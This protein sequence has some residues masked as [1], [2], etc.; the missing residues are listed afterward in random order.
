[1][2]DTMKIAVIGAGNIGTAMAAL[3]AQSGAEVTLVARG[4]RKAQ[5]EADG[6]RLDERGRMVT[7][8]P[9]VTEALAE[10]QDA[11][12]LCVKA[13]DLGAAV[14]ANRPGIGAGT[15]VIPM[16]NGLPF[17]FFTEGV[18]LADPDGALAGLDSACILGAVL[19]MTVRTEPD[20]TAVSSNTP[21]LTLAHALAGAGQGPA[22]ALVACLNA[23][24]VKTDLVADVRPKVLVKLLAN[25]ATNPLSALTGDMLA[26]IGRDSCLRALACAVAG[27]FRGWAAGLGYELPSDQWLVDLLLDAGDFPTSMLQDALAGRRLELDA[28]ARASLALS[29]ADGGDM[30]V[31]A[32]LLGLIDAAPSLPLAGPDRAAA[33]AGLTQDLPLERMHP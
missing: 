12:F 17:W 1:M 3:I 7:A 30:P 20:G 15:L 31:L 18:P 14:A 9:L 26:E 21:T 2:T 19:L 10:P 4:R 8:R 25:I 16:V 23:G 5:I 32:R 27:E 11:V 22:E 29:R 33:L 28:I 24:G 13:Q 6:L